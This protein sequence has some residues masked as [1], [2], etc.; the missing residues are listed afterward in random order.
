MKY[1]SKIPRLVQF[2]AIIALIG[3]I[4]YYSI[5]TWDAEYQKYVTQ[6][7]LSEGLA[8]AVPLQLAI[9]ESVSTQNNS[10]LACPPRECKFLTKAVD[11]LGYVETLSADKSGIISVV[12]S[13]NRLQLRG[14]KLML[15]PRFDGQEVDL[16]ISQVSGKVLS[17]VCR[18]GEG[19][20]IDPRMLPK[21]CRP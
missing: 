3:L 12:Y 6:S 17:W 4:F 13:F 8:I 14:V 7:I 10:P 21:P 9:A 15:M 16:S 19:T 11:P 20:D 2:V 1:F 18:P 5:R